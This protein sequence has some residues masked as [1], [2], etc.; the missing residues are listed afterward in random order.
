MKQEERTRLTQ[1]KIINAAMH[2][3]SEK[4]FAEASINT[5]CGQ[6]GISKGI[7]Y[8]HF[9]DKDNL[10]L[11][12][13][14][15]CFGAFES[16]LKDNLIL[17]EQDPG[18]RL[19]Q[20]FSIRQRFFELNPYYRGFFNQIM[21]VTPNHLRDEI[22]ELR[23]S[24]RQYNVIVLAEILGESTLRKDI[25]FDEASEILLFLQGALV[26]SNSM[27]EAASIGPNATE[28]LALRWVDILLHGI[29]EKPKT[30]AQ[31]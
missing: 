23:V 7:V 10:Y 26:S 31:T 1:R 14:R 28:S 19:V 12:C 21:T 17:N 15:E 24:L 29:L 8:H 27:R 5:I 20:Y 3:F 13:A 6:D 11:A 4:S 30:E 16:Y 25:T 2:E 9:K 22:N 18:S